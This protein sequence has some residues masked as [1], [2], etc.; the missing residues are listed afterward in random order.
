VKE[1]LKWVILGII[2][3]SVLPILFKVL[4][5]RAKAKRGV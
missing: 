1:N 4:Q 2:V 3:V 5:E